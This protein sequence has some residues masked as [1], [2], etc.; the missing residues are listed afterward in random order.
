LPARSQFDDVYQ[1]N[2]QISGWGVVGLTFLKNVIILFQVTLEFLGL[3]V[4]MVRF[5]YE[6][7][8]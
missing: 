4:I 3:I 8:S 5:C 2:P 6:E 7:S 1:V